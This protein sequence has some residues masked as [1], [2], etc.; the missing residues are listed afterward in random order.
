MDADNLCLRLP[1]SKTG[2]K[3]VH[4]GAAALEA[5]EAVPEVEGNPYLLPGWKGEGHLVG[6]QSTWERTR[7]AAGLG[8]VRLHDLRQA[9]ASLG[10]RGGDSLLVI[11]AL[12]GHRS[13]KTTQRYTHLSDHPLKDAA[14]RIS[15]EAARLMGSTRVP[16]SSARRARVVEAPPGTR[17]VLGEVIGTRW[18]DTKSAAE[19]V[20]L[21]VST[22]LTYKW[23]GTGP[24]CRKI[25]RR[26]V[27]ALGDLEAWRKTQL[28]GDQGRG[29][30]LG[31]L[32]LSGE[33]D[34]S[35]RS[36]C[37]GSGDS[38]RRVRGAAQ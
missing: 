30:R 36:E 34:R 23:N 7:R 21:A 4:I 22:L 32:R 38:R 33:G 9:F 35:L 27:Y 19:F 3:V 18:L 29:V 31:T 12:L 17:G 16:A 8:D 24:R 13:P 15:A 26:I 25:G 5:I 20:G 37:R 11:G 1:D 6:L 28:L 10:A 2:A 14:E